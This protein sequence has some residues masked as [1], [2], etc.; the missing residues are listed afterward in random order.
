EL[1]N[2]Y[3]V[4]DLTGPRS[5]PQ[6]NGKKE[7]SIRDVKSYER[8]LRRSGQRLT[9]RQRLDETI[10]DLNEERPRPVLGGR[11]AREVF[12]QDNVKLPD[13]WR[14]RKEVDRTEE[15]LLTIARSRSEQRSARRRAIEEVLL[16]YCL[17]KES[18]DVSR[19]YEARSRTD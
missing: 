11:T 19:N 4:L 15:R 3:E 1:L 6:Y 14:L 12:T 10:H 8:A 2:R 13:R 16:R 18:G 7:R 17:M 9:L 5:Y